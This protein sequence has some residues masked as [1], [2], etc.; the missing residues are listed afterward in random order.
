MYIYIYMMCIY[1]YIHTYLYVVLLHT[2]KPSSMFPPT[3]CPKLL[4]L[5]ASWVSSVALE[6]LHNNR[7]NA[8]TKTLQYS[9]KRF[10]RALWASAH[11]GP[12]EG[13]NL[14]QPEKTI[15]KKNWRSVSNW[16]YRC[17][18]NSSVTWDPSMR[19]ALC[20]ISLPFLHRATKATLRA[21]ASAWV[22]FLKFR[23][24]AD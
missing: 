21:V 12:E 11:C 18:Q 16:N 5:A 19:K 14:I 3:S 15:S 17:A 6:A 1:I 13:K 20:N 7:N 8:F 24:L 23:S 9:F 4:W 10:K 22:F 2:C